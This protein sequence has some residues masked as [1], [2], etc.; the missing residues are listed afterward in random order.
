MKLDCESWKGYFTHPEA[1][2]GAFF[3][4]LI[5]DLFQLFQL[6]NPFF[7]DQS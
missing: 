1:A 7:G 3:A 5:F 6:A 2:Q 4:M